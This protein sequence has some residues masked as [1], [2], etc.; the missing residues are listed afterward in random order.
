MQSEEYVFYISF[1][2]SH[3][4]SLANV[5]T[6]IWTYFV[7]KNLKEVLNILINS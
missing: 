1:F 2:M 7:S 3:F 4:V 6:F 5:N